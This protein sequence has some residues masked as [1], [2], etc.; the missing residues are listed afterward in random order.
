M[1]RIQTYVPA[2]TRTA[3]VEELAVSPTAEVEDPV[4]PTTTTGDPN[5][6]KLQELSVTAR[7]STHLVNPSEFTVDPLFLY[8]MRD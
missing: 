3:P 2:D 1:M 7:N 4:N 6:G 5:K 8:Y